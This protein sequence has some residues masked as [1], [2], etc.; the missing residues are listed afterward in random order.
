MGSLYTHG[1]RQKMLARATI[2]KPI[3]NKTVEPT[4]KPADK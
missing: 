4:V 1:A 3:K 2:E